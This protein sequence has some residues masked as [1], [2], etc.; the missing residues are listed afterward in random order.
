MGALE[1][2]SAEH[3]GVR[4]RLGQHRHH[5][6]AESFHSQCAKTTRVV[7]ARLLDE[8]YGTGPDYSLGMIPV[9]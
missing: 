3:N 6:R 1:Q 8:G 2:M 4:P 7:L 9:V 5:G